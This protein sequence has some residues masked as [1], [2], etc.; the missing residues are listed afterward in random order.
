MF[1]NFSTFFSD[2]IADV[3]TV[4]SWTLEIGIK[5]MANG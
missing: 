2:P 5:K 1:E 3:K 4:V